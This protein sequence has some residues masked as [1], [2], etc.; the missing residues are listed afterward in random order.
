M[1][2]PP[3]G[4]RAWGSVFPAWAGMSPTAA[5]KIR[6]A[7][8]FPAWAGMSR[9]TLRRLGCS[10]SFPRVSGDGPFNGMAGTRHEVFSLRERG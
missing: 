6:R 7:V 9:R 4:E 2:P 5:V 3:T 8:C 1:S 10:T